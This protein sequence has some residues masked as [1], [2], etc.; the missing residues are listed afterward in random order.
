[1]LWSRAADILGRMNDP[2]TLLGRSSSRASTLWN[3]RSLSGAGEIAVNGPGGAP[4]R[5]SHS[6]SPCRNASYGPSHKCRVA[7]RPV[8]VPRSGGLSR[9]GGASR[10]EYWPGADSAEVNY[11]SG[12]TCTLRSVPRALDTHT[13]SQ[14]SCSEKACRYAGSMVAKRHR[15]RSTTWTGSPTTSEMS[16]QKLCT[17]P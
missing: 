13:R 7:S 5:V 10:I 12:L 1:M 4:D 9:G 3:D 15:T 11:G 2:S 14:A 16:V 17:S 8:P 6:C